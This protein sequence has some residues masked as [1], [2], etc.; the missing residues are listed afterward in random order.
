[1]LIVGAGKDFRHFKDK[2]FW[3]NTKLFAIVEKVDV[4][5]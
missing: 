3:I 2:E 4:W 5:F 1:M